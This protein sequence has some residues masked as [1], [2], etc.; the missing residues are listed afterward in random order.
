M[1][2]QYLHAEDPSC[3][4]QLTNFLTQTSL[5]KLLQNQG[6]MQKLYTNAN[7][8]SQWV[9]TEPNSAPSAMADSSF[10]TTY[11]S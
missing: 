5:Q 1:H 7:S 10:V 8:F 6:G 4:F 2:T 3:M 11:H 9:T